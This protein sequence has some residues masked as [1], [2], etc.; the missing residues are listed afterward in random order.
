MSPQE[1]R[2]HFAR[3]W[4]R[5]L[6]EYS[7]YD[8]IGSVTGTLDVAGREVAVADW[9][10][11]RDHSW[12]VR[13]RVGIPEPFTGDVPSPDASMFAFLFFSTDASGGH[14][15][16]SSRGGS[17]H[18]T[19]E[20]TD[21]GSGTTMTGSQIDLEAT[22]VDAE[23]PRRFD[24]AVFDVTNEHG[25]VTHIE[26][27]SQG[28]AVAMTG[29]GYGGYDDRGGLGVYRG[30]QHLE[31]DIWEV[32]HPAAVGLPDGSTIRPV[33]RI[34]P[35]RVTQTGPH[36]TSEGNGSLT[37]IA[38]LDLDPDGALRFSAHR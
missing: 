8:Q 5:V 14:V 26:A 18:M 28:P 9:W 24:R 12:G 37:F 36:G 13:E 27:V 15:Q 31:H 3:S 1:E 32:T 7:R 25:D 20:I 38:E 17:S 23:R 29:L 4:G 22:F 10:G 30:L 34:Q 21:L 35:V 19:A 2:V 6:E 11:C 33:H 16:A